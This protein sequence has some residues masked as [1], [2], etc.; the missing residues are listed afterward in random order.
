MELEQIG[1]SD[2]PDL[3]GN[4]NYV[5]MGLRILNFEYCG[6]GK[7][8]THGTGTKKEPRHSRLK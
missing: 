4:S 3:Q 2:Q 5:E 7:K 1:Q 6:Y 8:P